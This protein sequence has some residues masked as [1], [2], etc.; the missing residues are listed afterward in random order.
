LTSI[1]R[2]VQAA[3]VATSLDMAHI[4]MD[5]PAGRTDWT[6]LLRK[7]MPYVDIFLPGLEETFFM[8]DRSRF[9][10]MSTLAGGEALAVYGS[11]LLLSELGGRLL[12]MGAAVAGLKL[13]DQGLYLRTTPDAERLA[14]VGQLGLGAKWLGREL[15]APAF[16]VDVAGTTGAGDCAIAG[17]LAALLRGLGPEAALIAAAGAGACNVEAPDG[18]SG[19]P[20]WDA[21][22]ARI[23]AGW[24]QAPLRVP[25]AGWQPAPGHG[26]WT[27]PHD[28]GFL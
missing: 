22:Q 26:L 13:G 14:H 17:F 3:G 10:G 28:A 7:V 8:L 24:R 6:A 9:E 18:I 1:F 2:G 15:L 5:A 19:V 25:L 20:T 11:G 12:E 4:D 23:E 27:G 21:L 16:Q